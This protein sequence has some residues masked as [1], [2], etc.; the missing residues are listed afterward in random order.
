ARA[1]LLDP[2][3]VE[4][5]ARRVPPSLPLPSATLSATECPPELLA[6]IT[7]ALP[8]ATHDGPERLDGPYGQIEQLERRA[9]CRSFL[10]APLSERSVTAPSRHPPIALAPARFF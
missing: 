3:A 9:G 1:S 7:V 8:D 2:A 4:Y 5:R 6:E 10:H